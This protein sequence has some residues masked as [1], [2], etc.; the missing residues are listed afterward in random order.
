MK[1]KFVATTLLCVAIGVSAAD[2]R[3]G[4]FHRGGGVGSVEC[5]QFVAIMSRAKV[6]GI[7]SI[8]YANETYGFVSYVLGFQ[9]A[10]NINTKDT[11]DIF[12]NL[13]TDQLLAWAEN[14][15]QAKPLERFGT[16]VV[17]LSFEVYGK[18]IR[19]CQ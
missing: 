9:T 14:Y 13:S 5:P 2:D 1:T 6:Q 16:A 12:G 3:S 17:A 8:G 7:G 10:Y 19:T 18:R 15:C 4:A 11:C